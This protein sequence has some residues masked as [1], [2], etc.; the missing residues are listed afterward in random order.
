MA[1]SRDS[2]G[3]GFKIVVGNFTLE[4]AKMCV[5]ELFMALKDACPTISFGF[6]L[7]HEPEE[8][9]PFGIVVKTVFPYPRS[10]ASVVRLAQEVVANTQSSDD[11][12]QLYCSTLFN[13]SAYSDELKEL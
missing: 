7:H 8:N 9:P 13:A 12:L 1:R 4:E 10:L 11:S 6:K 5:V 2:F 3:K